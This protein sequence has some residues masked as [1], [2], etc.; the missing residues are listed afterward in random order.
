MRWTEIVT[1]PRS[2]LAESGLALVYVLVLTPMGLSRRR[3]RRLRLDAVREPST[4]S[5]WSACAISTRD[6]DMFRRTS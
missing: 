1:R 5:R 3:R 6:R 4:G 2:F